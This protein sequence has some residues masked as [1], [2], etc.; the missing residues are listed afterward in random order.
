M[1]G[2]SDNIFTATNFFFTY[3]R[4]L[5]G[6]QTVTL[7]FQ[8]KAI[9]PEIEF[10]FIL[11]IVVYQFLFLCVILRMRFPYRS[12]IAIRERYGSHIG[13]LLRKFRVLFGK[14]RFICNIKQNSEEILMFTLL[15][16]FN[17]GKKI[18]A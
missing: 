1:P 10:F 9:F 15:F 6:F 12:H 7:E 8:T 5:I 11:K 3:N 17:K 13:V 18:D 16:G 14:L 2:F 4:F